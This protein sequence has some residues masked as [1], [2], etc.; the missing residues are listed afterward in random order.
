MLLEELNIDVSDTAQE[1][2]E[3]AGK[4]I[5]AKL[6]ELQSTQEEIR[7]IFA[8][9]PSQDYMLSYLAKS[10]RIEWSKIV[11]FNMD[12]YIGLEKGAGQLFSRYLEN[13]LFSRV[14]PKAKYFIDPSRSVDEEL[15]RV[16]KLID[17]KPI[18]LVCLGIGQ[19]GHIAFNDPP[20]ADFEDQL[21]IK[22]VELDAV[23]RMQQVQDKCFDT[24]DMV[25]T[26]ALTLTIPTIMRANSLFCVVVGEHKQEAVKHTL[27]SAITTQWPSTILRKHRDCWFFFDR[28]AC[29]SA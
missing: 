27:T 17:E 21:L 15:K 12:E 18:D 16:S 19:N 20:V 1:V 24:I 5:E 9:A 14:T 6:V 28:A 10:D 4:A 13:R 2:G 23:C 25:P 8:A 3:K 7:V 29:P 22:K 11:A 26:H